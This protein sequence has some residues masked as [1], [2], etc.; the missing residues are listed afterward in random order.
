MR[1]LYQ[2]IIVLL[3]LM[4]LSCTC[5]AFQNDNIAY[6]HKDVP[7][8]LNELKN[9]AHASYNE[10]KIEEAITI[11]L[12]LIEQCFKLGYEQY[13]VDLYEYIGDF[14]ATQEGISISQ[15][16]KTIALY[17]DTESRLNLQAVKYS[18]WAQAYLA[19]GII[20]TANLY[21]NTALKYCKKDNLWLVNTNM[22][23][24]FSFFFYYSN[25]FK[26]TLEYIKKAETIAEEK[27]APN[28]IEVPQNLYV[29]Q[30][31]VYT[32][33]GYKE[34]AIISDIK[35]IEVIKEDNSVSSSA[36]ADQYLHLAH[37]Y[38]ELGDFDNAIFYYKKSIELAKKYN[39]EVLYGIYY[40][41][42]SLASCYQ[43]QGQLTRAQNVYNNL[44][45]KLDE[46]NSTKSDY[47]LI[48]IQSHQSLAKL[49]MEKQLYDSV[50]HC[51]NKLHSIHKESK[52][53]RWETQNINST[54][55]TLINNYEQAEQYAYKALQSVKKS[56]NTNINDNTPYININIALINLKTK[57]YHK[58]LSFCQQSLTILAPGFSTEE[59]Y[60][61]P[62]FQDIFHKRALIPVINTKLQVLE[63][64]Y[65]QKDPNV[66]PQLLLSTIKLGIE[67]LEYKNK[68][69][70]SKSSQIYWLNKEAIPL[71]EKAIR[72]ALD[73]YERTQQ[74]QYLNEAFMLSERSKS[75]MMMNA[76]Q[77]Q[78]A[79]SFGGIPPQLIEREQEL[80]REF[81]VIEKARQDAEMMK[82]TAEMR[83]Q[84]S[85]LFDYHHEKTTLLQH[86]ESKYP[87]YFELKHVVSQTS[88][89]EVQAALDPQTLLVE[90]FQGQE[91]I[92]VFTISKKQAF[93][94]H[95]QHNKIYDVQLASF[96]NLLID[97]DRANRNINGTYR[98][99][100]KASHDLYQLLLANS[101][102]PNKSRLI[103][104]PDGQLAY[105]PFEV[106]LS[107]DLVNVANAGQERVEFAALPYL[108][109]D[110]TTNY[111]Y[112]AQLF[113]QQRAQ[114]QKNSAC[115][116]LALAP[117][118]S[119]K[120][121]PNWRNPY[122]RKLREHLE[123]LPG[124]VRE[125]QFLDKLF[126]GDFLYNKD[127]NETN[128][129]KKAPAYDILHLA[130]HGLVDN[131]KPELSG[132][133][134]EENNSR[135]EDNILYAYEIKQLDLQAQLV[136]LSACE[137]GIGKYQ[138]GEGVMS[139]GRGF[140]YAGVP[141]LMTTLWSLNDQS[142]PFIMKA[143]YQNLQ[144]GLPKDKAL[145][146]AKLHYLKH[147]NGV[148]AYPAL[149][150]CFVQ[151]GDYAPLKIKPNYQKWYYGGVGILAV[152]LI[153]FVFL[154]MRKK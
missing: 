24:G 149:W 87:K 141:S 120:T 43:S 134:L 148:A 60:Q 38:D 147:Y 69:F 59:L 96:Q 90:Y 116:I 42:Y 75:M 71:F 54:Y 104:I 1:S 103:L 50:S 143:F 102:M 70:K 5:Q 76:L 101:L 88:I 15:K 30:G 16:K 151:V 110:Y 41:T 26:K 27:L 80:E 129:K 127:A 123:E 49:Y 137:T 3:L 56:T 126:G 58:A 132:L 79:T 55:N 13:T 114:I 31:M 139:I 33:L 52:F 74:P 6:N 19:H 61:N 109:R 68:N 72:I 51:I 9:S 47:Y 121:A 32:I 106:L 154:K 39:L 25:N 62:K 78:N 21:Y 97:T 36:L 4:A 48:K 40:P 77:E 14:V 124:A 111:N 94:H 118:Y 65:A 64:L 23:I 45:S 82:D 67:A 142:T 28:N 112:S 73:L 12:E 57:N 95:F 92:Y 2:S 91:Q 7:D 150:A 35:T 152:L 136:V 85:L 29:M 66:T 107:K 138:R 144:N 20:D 86:F 131:K 146:H 115:R 130:V 119:N 135:L 128:F 44:I 84:D 133:A 18:Y 63:A 22:N 145:R 153:I 93:V 125:L 117:S 100:V 46:I 8:Y 81:K 34:K 140:M 53:R 113:L 10:G 105:L 122:E 89:Q 108:L 11:T 83:Y 98:A 37:Q 17:C 99:F